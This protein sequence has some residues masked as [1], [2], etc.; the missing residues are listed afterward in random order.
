M[1]LWLVEVVTQRLPVKAG[2]PQSGARCGSPAP[3]E[4]TR[5]LSSHCRSYAAA[6]SRGLELSAVQPFS[7]S[8]SAEQLATGRLANDRAGDRL[9]ARLLRRALASGVPP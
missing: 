5:S 6:S 8:A 4:C 2:I 9:D 3:L 1:P 7:R